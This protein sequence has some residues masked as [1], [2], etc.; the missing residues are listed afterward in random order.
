MWESG[1]VGRISKRGGKAG[2]L[3]LG[4]FQAFHGAS[5][6]QPGARESRRA[7]GPRDHPALLRRLARTAPGGHG[8]G[9]RARSKRT[10]R[11]G[12]ENR[13]REGAKAMS[14]E[15]FPHMLAQLA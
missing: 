9:R 1:V 10:G 5:F 2:K 12:A 4:V 7:G 15:L 11:A 6:P 14:A 3:V 8:R 13:P